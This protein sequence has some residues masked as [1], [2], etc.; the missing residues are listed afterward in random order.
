MEKAAGCNPVLTFGGRM[1]P[2]VTLTILTV[3]AVAAGLYFGWSSLAAVGLTGV[4]VSLVPCL[5][6]CAAGICMSRMG[7]N[8][9]AA[10]KAP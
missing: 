6:M 1:K 2:W 3:A 7:G 8:K 9:E 4:I 5:V 10:D